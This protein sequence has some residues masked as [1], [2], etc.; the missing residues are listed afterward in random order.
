MAVFSAFQIHL[1]RELYEVSKTISRNSIL[2][3]EEFKVKTFWI[4]A[5]G[6]WYPRG[7]GFYVKGGVGVGSLG[8]REL[9][10]ARNSSPLSSS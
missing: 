10:P 1:Q 3:R 8:L 2:F 9:R 4:L 7:Q 6:T 5:T